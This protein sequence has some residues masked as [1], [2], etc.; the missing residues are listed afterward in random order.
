MVSGT[1]T[2]SSSLLDSEEPAEAR[3]PM[4][5]NDWPLMLTVWPTGEP[6][7][8]SSVAVSEPITATD[9]EESTSAW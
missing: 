1:T 8:N 7:V 5:V 4:T 6:V 9:A 2:V 3:T